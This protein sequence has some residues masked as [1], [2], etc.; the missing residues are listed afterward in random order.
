MVPTAR[1]LHGLSVLVV[2]D[3]R[4]TVDM[5]QQYLTLCGA[6]VTGAGSAK[7][8]LA[9]LET[10]TVD[11]AVV[12]LRMP[13]EDGWAF[14]SQLRASRTASAHAAV[15]A[16]SGERYDQL[17]TA[18]GFAGYFF[19]PVD[20]DALVAALAALPRRSESAKPC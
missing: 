2:D 19:K 16:I 20:L 15:F 7:A 13:G 18:S 14:L 6:Q 1:S 12:D 5:F 3:H 17:D 11:A 9:V 10:H 8:A 4:D